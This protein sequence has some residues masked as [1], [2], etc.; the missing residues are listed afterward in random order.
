MIVLIGWTP[1]DYDRFQVQSHQYI[2]QNRERNNHRLFGMTICTGGGSGGF[3]V[4]RV[5]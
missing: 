5:G 3:V 1:V 2:K 4:G